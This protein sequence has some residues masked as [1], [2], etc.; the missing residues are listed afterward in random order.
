MSKAKAIKIWK[1]LVGM[2]VTKS[3]DVVI[4]TTRV[5]TVFA[6]S[7]NVVRGI[8]LIR[9]VTNLGRGLGKVST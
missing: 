9:Y 4:T 2:E 3:F 7:M 1:Q 6:F 8:V 5:E